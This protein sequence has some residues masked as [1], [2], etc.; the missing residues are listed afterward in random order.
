MNESIVSKTAEYFK[1]KGIL[2][3]KISELIEPNS[4]NQDIINQLKLIDKNDINPLNLFRVH[5]YNSRNDANFSQTPEYV[6]LPSEFTG[7]EAKIIVNILK[8]L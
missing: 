8:I 1:K 5:W 4:I 7:I 2:L 3:P 6:L